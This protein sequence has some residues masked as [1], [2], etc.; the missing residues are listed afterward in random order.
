MGEEGRAEN[1]LTSRTC[2]RRISGPEDMT[3]YTSNRT[4]KRKNAENRAEHPR[5][6][7]QQSSLP[8]RGAEGECAYSLCMRETSQCPQ[9]CMHVALRKENRNPI[10][11]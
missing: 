8:A 6:V 2:L 3:I 1:S 10:L 11:E 9:T 4:A 5:P 7:E